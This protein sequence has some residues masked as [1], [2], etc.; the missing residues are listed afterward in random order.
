M[1]Y[2]ASFESSQFC[3]EEKYHTVYIN[4]ISV[5]RE[6]HTV[7]GWYFVIFWSTV[8]ENNT[9]IKSDASDNMVSQQKA[10]STTLQTCP[11]GICVMKWTL[12][13]ILV[14]YVY[15]SFFLFPFEKAR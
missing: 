2:R 10:R 4:I 15:T 13:H 1:F 5:W 3:K 11:L 12:K 14:K 9:E 6:D 7:V 8:K